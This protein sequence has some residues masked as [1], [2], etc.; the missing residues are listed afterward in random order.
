MVKRVAPPEELPEHGI[1]ARLRDVAAERHRL[2][3]EEAA[4]VRRARNAGFSWEAIAGSLGVTRQA[5]HKKYGR[6]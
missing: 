1:L 6:R 4:L 2:E 5:V 3:Q